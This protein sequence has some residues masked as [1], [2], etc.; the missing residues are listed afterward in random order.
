MAGEIIVLITASSEDEAAKIGSALVDEH[1]AACVNIV[2]G[3]RSLFF[4]E[5]K[6]QDGRELLLIC[7]SRQPLLGR[8]IARV[9][10]LHSYT[11]PEV[12]ALPVVGGSEDYLRW[13]RE[14]TRE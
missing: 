12:I 10:S 14:A 3:V 9:K 8:L 5:E 2:P 7:K 4:W 11:V 13:L 1:L 6:T